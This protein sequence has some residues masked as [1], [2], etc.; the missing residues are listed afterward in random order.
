MGLGHGNRLGF[1]R[2]DVHVVDHQA[3]RIGFAS[4]PI[5]VLRADDERP[6][7]ARRQRRRVSG[8][9]RA[10]DCKERCAPTRSS[11]DR[12]GDL[13]GIRIRVYDLGQHVEI[14]RI[15]SRHIEEPAVLELGA[16]ILAFADHFN[17]LLADRIRP[18]G[19]G[20]AAD[21]D[22]RRNRLFAARHVDDDFQSCLQR[23]DFSLDQLP[24]GV[25]GC[26]IDRLEYV[27]RP[28]LFERCIDRGG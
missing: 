6:A 14:H 18:M 3:G 8:Q 20:V 13:E 16:S 22:C 25:I 12:V 11:I 26:D 7:R 17:D 19:V 15:G 5:G 27:H 28:V 4:I 24:V 9:R 1:R 23:Q 21:F 10:I 2:T